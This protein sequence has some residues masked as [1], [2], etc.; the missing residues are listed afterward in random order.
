MIHRWSLLFLLILILFLPVQAHVPIS[1]NNNDNINAAFSVENPVKSY[2]VYGDLRR[3]GD[4]AYYRFS[5]N[6]GDRLSLSLMTTGY[7]APLPEM[8]IM[9]PAKAAGQ[10]SVPAQVTIPA[11]YAAEVV[12]GQKPGNADYEPFSP[13]AVFDIANYSR[14]ITVPGAYY[15]AVISLSDETRYSLAVG[16][17][18]EFTPAEWVLVPVN[19]I[20]THVW[21]GQSVVAV[22]A[23]LLAVIVFGLVL[24]ARREHRKGTKPSLPFWLASCAGLFYLGGAAI[25]LVQMGRALRMTGPSPAVGVTLVF[26]LVPV[27]LGLWALRIARSPAPR[28][29][30]NRVFLVMVGAL[31]LVFWAGLSSVL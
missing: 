25:T 6:S 23:P 11:G 22:L 18:E 12:S 20:S 30:R 2:V 10:G 16:Y 14:Q 19:V 15:V 27:V 21:E 26:A 5:M 3:A 24:I 28:S 9:S 13:A 4:V 8:I 17:R 31:G 29:L 1:A 7:D